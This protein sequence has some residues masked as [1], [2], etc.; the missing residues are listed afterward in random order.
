MR[1]SKAC[2]IALLAILP[3]SAPAQDGPDVDPAIRAMADLVMR[4]RLEAH[5]EQNFWSATE[6]LLAKYELDPTE[7]ERALMRE[8]GLAVVPGT[9]D[10]AIGPAYAHAATAFAPEE[11][12]V[13]DAAL[14]AGGSSEIEDEALRARFMAY[15]GELGAVVNG[16]V[17]PLIAERLGNY[18]F[19]AWEAG[20]D[21]GFIPDGLLGTR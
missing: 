15:Q 6:E 20:E 14:A 3:L 11:A 2:A 18:R 13:I 8:A 16:E 4:A 17:G 5:I 10:H 1:L 19:E 7:E 9:Y 21:A 12:A